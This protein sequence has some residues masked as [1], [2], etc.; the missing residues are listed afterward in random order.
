[1][2]TFLFKG[3][4]A[5]IFLSTLYLKQNR[6]NIIDISLV[7]SEPLFYLEVIFVWNIFDYTIGRG[8]SQ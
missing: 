2:N 3:V 4:G 6:K 5:D 7:T 8:F 1:M